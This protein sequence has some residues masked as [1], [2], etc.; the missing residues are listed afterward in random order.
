MT[1]K[2]FII[3]VMLIVVAAVVGGMYINSGI[4]IAP[5]EGK[6]LSGPK[7]VQGISTPG[8]PTEAA[9]GTP[10]FAAIDQSGST[11]TKGY[12]IT[13]QA[14]GSGA[15]LIDGATSTTSFP[16]GTIDMGTFQNLLSSVGDVSKIT[17][18]GGCVKSASFG[19][20]TTIVYNGKTSTDLQ[21]VTQGSKPAGA[22]DLANFVLRVENVLQV[23][24]L[25]RFGPH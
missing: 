7:P 19:T 1:K 22:Y 21:C 18:A 24:G 3:I 23:S 15:V 25:D 10:A 6:A 13:I 14:D 4:V 8:T 5:N 11:N 2:A 16:V 9:T 17:A 12:A 20:R